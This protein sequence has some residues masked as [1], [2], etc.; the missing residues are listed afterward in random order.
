[1]LQKYKSSVF[2]KSKKRIRNKIK[3]K[4]TKKTR[5]SFR[6]VTMYGGAYDTNP[7]FIFPEGSAI[8]HGEFS[9]IRFETISGA[10][11]NISKNP[12][13]LL[14][15]CPPRNW[16]G[17]E[18]ESETILRKMIQRVRMKINIANYINNTLSGMFFLYGS[19]HHIG[20]RS[21][22]GKY[23]Y[24]LFCLLNRIQLLAVLLKLK[25]TIPNFSDI[26]VHFPINE[27]STLPGDY[28]TFP[29]G[30]FYQWDWWDSKDIK[31]S[32]F[33]AFLENIKQVE[34]TLLEL[35]PFD[36]TVVGDVLKTQQ[37]IID[38]LEIPPSL[39]LQMFKM[40]KAEIINSKEVTVIDPEEEE[41]QRELKREKE[42]QRQKHEEHER[43]K[44]EEDAQKRDSHNKPNDKDVI[45]AILFINN[46]I[47]RMNNENE[48]SVLPLPLNVNAIDYK[49][50]RRIRSPLLK[51]L[52]PGSLSQE[53][54]EISTNF[55][56]KLDI[57]KRRYQPQS[58]GKKKKRLL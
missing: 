39:N 14:K 30:Y 20:H 27:S 57:L 22:G 51:Y 58:A 37:Q 3:R 17:Y 52:D 24:G 21:G 23:Y 36:T 46:L 42:I 13:E 19:D 48:T 12:N 16:K 40:T 8:F 28:N 29:H 43:L 1:M 10:T 26:D 49:D 11:Y 2:K 9:T 32:S 50:I 35:P 38:E 53:N 34:T 7:F 33:I 15:L 4:Q 44:R 25:R 18:S 5:K 47:V 6:L 55:L 45:A 54:R 41:Y 31:L 56:N